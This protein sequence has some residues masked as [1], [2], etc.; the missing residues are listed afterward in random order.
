MVVRSSLLF[1][2]INAAGIAMFLLV[3]SCFWIEPELADVPGANGG[4]GFGWIIFAAPIPAIFL[5]GDPLLL[6]M[7]LVK[8]GWADR[9]RH[10]GV[11]L[12][13]LG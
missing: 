10:I 1:L 13:V 3:A 6:A 9:V 11:S 7:K 4:N 8:S 5:L 12:A 2:V